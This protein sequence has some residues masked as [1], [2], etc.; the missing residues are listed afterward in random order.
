[1]TLP[2]PTIRPL[3]RFFGSKWNLAIKYPPPIYPIVVEPFAGAAGYSTRYWDRQVILCEKDPKI[4]A[5]WQW[6]L[7]AQPE[8]ILALPLLAP[9]E[10]VPLWLPAGARWFLGF[11]ATVNGAKPQRRMVPSAGSVA[12][13]CWC[14]KVRA[15]TAIAVQR[16]RHWTIW[17]G[18]YE[19]LPR[20]PDA[21]YFV[22]PPY[23]PPPS[24]KKTD[25]YEQGSKAINYPA[26]AEWVRGIPGQAIVCENLGA[27]WLPF[28]FLTK[29]HSTPRF[30]A[31]SPGTLEVV[32]HQILG[33]DCT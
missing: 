26:L 33:V 29:G 23:V 22:D 12:G 20:I 5:I 10:E 15:R 3:F 1:M 17:P 19:T 2:D 6:L 27:E 9:G 18:S 32:Y 28:K 8:E 13:N 11:W 7:T 25:M 31:G 24:G 30:A 4:A 21:T 14:E 16:I